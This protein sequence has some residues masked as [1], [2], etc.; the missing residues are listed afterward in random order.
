MGRSHLF[1]SFFFSA[2]LIDLKKQL[3]S[4]ITS[5]DW[6]N[7]EALTKRKANNYFSF[8]FCQIITFGSPLTH[9]VRA[10]ARIALQEAKECTLVSWPAGSFVFFVL[11]FSLEQDRVSPQ[12]KKAMKKTVF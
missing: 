10:A 11:R 9:P 1:P 2:F 4:A 8:F 7:A 12:R 5:R 6:L 3:K